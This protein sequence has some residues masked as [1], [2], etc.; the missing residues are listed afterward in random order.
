MLRG[1]LGYLKSSIDRAPSENFDDNKRQSQSFST[2]TTNNNNNQVQTDKDE[3]HDVT[4]EDTESSGI[5]DTIEDIVQENDLSNGAD[6]EEEIEV[7]H[8]LTGNY[9]YI[10]NISDEVI[11]TQDTEIIQKEQLSDD[12]ESD[13][14][15]RPLDQPVGISARY[16]SIA[17]PQLSIIE[18]DSISGTENGSEEDDEHETLRL[19]ELSRREQFMKSYEEF[20]SSTP[21]DDDEDDDENSYSSSDQFL[22][23]DEISVLQDFQSDEDVPSDQQKISLKLTVSS[24]HDENV[25]SGDANSNNAV[26]SVSKKRKHDEVVSSDGSEIESDISNDESP[27][28]NDDANS[29]VSDQEAQVQSPGNNQQAQ[30]TETNF[31]YQTTQH[32]S[33]ESTQTSTST[34]P[35]QNPDGLEEPTPLNRTPLQS[36]MTSP[37]MTTQLVGDTNTTT[38]IPRRV[39]NL[40]ARIPS[41]ALAQIALF[42]QWTG[43]K[44]QPKVP[45]TAPVRTPQHPNSESEKPTAPVSPQ[46]KATIRQE[47]TPEIRKKRKYTLKTQKKQRLT[48]KEDNLRLE[49]RLRSKELSSI[50]DQLPGASVV[51]SSPHV[52]LES[53]S[54]SRRQSQ[55]SSSVTPAR[56]EGIQ[57]TNTPIVEE[58]AENHIQEQEDLVD[59]VSVHLIVANELSVSPEKEVPQTTPSV[60]QSQEAQQDSTR[61]IEEHDDLSDLNSSPVKSSVV[62]ER[63]VIDSTLNRNIESRRINSTERLVECVQENIEISNTGNLDNIETNSA[64]FTN[65]MRQLNSRSQVESEQESDKSKEETS[66]LEE[67]EERSQEPDANNTGESNPN[68]DDSSNDSSDD[69][70]GNDS[71]VA[72]NRHNQLDDDNIQNNEADDY[73]QDGSSSPILLSDNSDDEYINAELSEKRNN[74]KSSPLLFVEDDSESEKNLA[75]VS[76]PSFEHIDSI[77]LVHERSLNE[78]DTSSPIPQPDE[79]LPDFLDDLS[80]QEEIDQAEIDQEDSSSGS[81]NSIAQ[82]LSE[83]EPDHLIPRRREVDEVENFPDNGN[84]PKRRRLDDIHIT[85]DTG[86]DDNQLIDNHDQHHEEAVDIPEQQL[87]QPQESHNTES[88]LEEQI[89]P[90]ID[91]SLRRVNSLPSPE[92]N[93]EDPTGNDPFPDWKSD[94]SYFDK[95]LVDVDSLLEQYRRPHVIRTLAQQFVLTALEVLQDKIERVIA[96]IDTLFE[97]RPTT[98]SPEVRNESNQETRI[99]QD[100]QSGDAPTEE[101]PT[102]QYITPLIPLSEVQNMLLMRTR[103]RPS[104]EYLRKVAISNEEM[105]AA[106]QANISNAR[107]KDGITNS[108]DHTPPNEQIENQ[109]EYLP[110]DDDIVAAEHDQIQAVDIEVNQLPV[111]NNATTVP[112]SENENIESDKPLQ[113]EVATED[114]PG[115]PKQPSIPIV[116]EVIEFLD[117]ETEDQLTQLSRPRQSQ[118]STEVTSQNTKPQLIVSQASTQ[119]TQSQE[120]NPIVQSGQPAEPAEPTQTSQQTSQQFH[121]VNTD[122]DSITPRTVN[123]NDEHV[124]TRIPESQQEGTT[125]AD[126]QESSISQRSTQ[127]RVGFSQDSTDSSSSNKHLNKV[128]RINPALIIPA[129]RIQKSKNVFRL[130]NSS[131]EDSDIDE[132]IE[133]LAAEVE[134]ENLNLNR[135]QPNE[136][137]KESNSLNEG[138]EAVQTSN[139]TEEPRPVVANQQAPEDSDTVMEPADAPAQVGTGASEKDDSD[140]LETVMGRITVPDGEIIDEPIEI[141]EAVE[142]TPVQS[143]ESPINISTATRETHER[144]VVASI[145]SQQPVGESIP[146]IGGP[147]M[148][149]GQQESTYTPPDNDESAIVNTVQMGINPKNSQLQQNIVPETADQE[150]DLLRKAVQELKMKLREAERTIEQE[151]N[152]KEVVE[153]NFKEAQSDY[154][155][156]FKELSQQIKSSELKFNREEVARQQA[157]RELINL[158]QKVNEY[159]ESQGL[160]DKQ[161][162]QRVSELENHLIGVQSSLETEQ[163]NRER[164]ANVLLRER[165]EWTKE[166]RETEMLI[167]KEKTARLEVESHLQ[168]ARQENLRLSIE[169]SRTREVV[170]GKEETSLINVSELEQQLSDTRTEIEK[171]KRLR[172]IDEEEN[173]KLQ[174]A[175]DSLRNQLATAISNANNETNSKIQIKEKLSQYDKKINELS[176]ELSASQSELQRASMRGVFAEQQNETLKN[177]LDAATKEVKQLIERLKITMEAHSSVTQILKSV[178]DAKK[179]IEQKVEELENQLA[180][181][182]EDAQKDRTACENAEKKLAISLE[183]AKELAETQSIVAA[184]KEVAAREKFQLE[185]Q[186]IESERDQARRE[187]KELTDRLE[188]T[189]I[190]YNLEK[191]KYV[192]K[193]RELQKAKEMLSQVTRRMQAA[194]AVHRHEIQ[195]RVTREANAVNHANVLASNLHKLQIKFKEV[196]EDNRILQHEV[197][198]FNTTMQNVIESRDAVAREVNALQQNISMYR[199]QLDSERALRHSAEKSNEEA[200]ATLKQV[201]DERD[202]LLGQLQGA[203]EARWNSARTAA[204]AIRE[205]ESYRAR[206]DKEIM[207]LQKREASAREA[208]DLEQGAREIAENASRRVNNEFNNIK[209][210]LVAARNALEAE[211]SSKDI[212]ENARV[213]LE[214]DLNERTEEYEK[215]KEELEKSIENLSQEVEDAKKL[216]ENE[217]VER[218]TLQ[219]SHDQTIECYKEQQRELLQRIASMTVENMA[220]QR[221]FAENTAANLSRE[222]PVHLEISE[223]DEVNNGDAMEIDNENELIEDNEPQSSIANA[224][225]VEKENPLDEVADQLGDDE[226]KKDGDIMIADISDDYDMQDYINLNTLISKED[227]DQNSKE[228]E[229]QEFNSVQDEPNKGNEND[230]EIMKEREIVNIG[231]ELVII[232]QELVSI[233]QQVASIQQQEEEINSEQEIVNKEQDNDGSKEQ[234]DVNNKQDEINGPSVVKEATTETND[235][236]KIVEDE[237]VQNLKESIDEEMYDTLEDSDPEFA[238]EMDL[239]YQKHHSI[240]SSTQINQVL[241]NRTMSADEIQSQKSDERVYSSSVDTEAISSSA[242]SQ[243]FATSTQISDEQR[244]IAKQTID[245]RLNESL[246]TSD[247]ASVSASL[248]SEEHQEQINP[249]KQQ[250]EE[251]IDEFKELSYIEQE[252]E[253]RNDRRTLPSVTPKESTEDS[254]ETDHNQS[255]NVLEPA[256]HEANEIDLPMVT[257]LDATIAGS[258]KGTDHLNEETSPLEL[259]SDEPPVNVSENVYHSSL[260]Q[261][262]QAEDDKGESVEDSERSK[263]VRELIDGVAVDVIMLSLDSEDDDDE[264]VEEITIKESE[265]SV[266][267]L[268]HTPKE[269][270]TTDD[271]NIAEAGSRDDN[272]TPPIA[273]SSG[274][275]S[276]REESTGLTSREGSAKLSSMEDE[277]NH[278][279]N[280]A[281]SES[282]NKDDGNFVLLSKIKRAFSQR[283]KEVE[284]SAPLGESDVDLACMVDDIEKFKFRSWHKKSFETSNSDT[285]SSGSSSIEEDESGDSEDGSTGKR[286]SEEVKRTKDG[287]DRFKGSNGNDNDSKTS[288]IRKPKPIVT[289]DEIELV[290]FEPSSPNTRTIE[291]LN[292]VIDDLLDSTIK[293]SSKSSQS[294]EETAHSSQ[295]STTA[296]SSVYN[297]PFSPTIKANKSNRA[298]ARKKRR[299]AL[300]NR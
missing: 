248:E 260:Q 285:G 182:I 213:S 263:I 120:E 106:Y 297:V 199:L 93:L 238:K 54:P 242:K 9:N 44:T 277:S 56:D 292:N 17:R 298:K 22:P 16:G 296:S 159:F 237:V 236:A 247:S 61:I 79:M 170:N 176:A 12:E 62:H 27:E 40:P 192:S 162:N 53:N 58:S 70:R 262:S 149:E 289:I 207:E 119:T 286:T 185:I 258:S 265:T 114:T 177:E 156:R 239:G 246:S 123:E 75:S 122:L 290:P 36:S 28:P 276:S 268:V 163:K 178:L 278:P 39:A 51:P 274:V 38:R 267:K 137:G 29:P 223:S 132:T 139:T 80:D 202:E 14:T 190:A 204:E 109:E 244:T 164:I 169:I 155:L 252:L 96:N 186:R 160:V 41:E 87:V 214:K 10:K 78:N 136:S 92:Q 179:G 24:S 188:A 233:G 97:H 57:V 42:E 273:S 154:Q 50:Y 291:K 140:R 91:L 72:D 220:I 219:K 31:M 43:I 293:L 271:E 48:W 153:Q 221:D 133:S 279:S 45:T 287:L 126:T 47:R 21:D 98:T 99:E 150:K 152:E 15:R 212:V 124:Q 118:S 127:S 165:Q 101:Q 134:I 281:E 232:E 129:T 209:D 13:A 33:Q 64:Q 261:E 254:G 143:S 194:A 284:G 180:I 249:S 88:I 151:K 144:E 205:L 135:E 288:H 146:G 173:R 94:D 112:T 66:E 259:V 55:V 107:Q 81:A 195:V 6:E 104:P 108:N 142:P 49:E 86:A 226:S 145:M 222:E 255:T 206:M 131:D 100:T 264:E 166:L 141:I 110:N 46:N 116:I 250:P 175:N 85:N 224:E 74:R 227:E 63:G 235:P 189:N 23:K 11:E 181:A 216:I 191:E 77:S 102:E 193:D 89:A 256:T 299:Q 225:S 125:V 147:A 295:S 197:A 7:L 128:K 257:E 167:Q 1:V 280:D 184:D 82:A 121:Q 283:Y 158:E 201:T 269:S 19:A 83:V 95:V 35:R 138:E 3:D 5:H 251:E 105:E 103:L 59:E 68:K 231:Q 196:E 215:V 113:D 161:F 130:L 234:E 60:I 300:K 183:N 240:R 228:S 73:L 52:V 8:D 34:Q 230:D 245:L 208:L 275:S 115:S 200:Q 174:V 30:S 18:N 26:S 218:E 229:S 211:K 217:R 171:L 241:V 243:G 117:I 172:R 32:H 69:E 90:H 168:R 198:N 294:Q 71:S 4:S 65:S 282:G 111:S 270:N 37:P 25:Q 2:T 203:T 76:P 272:Y 253:S 266:K 157:E 187:A 148:N 20:S 84:S 67:E 210:Q